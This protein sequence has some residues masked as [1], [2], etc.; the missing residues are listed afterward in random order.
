[1]KK[2]IQKTLLT[3]IIV[4]SIDRLLGLYLSTLYENN[5]YDHASGDVNKILKGKTSDTLI[6]G[7]SRVYTMIDPNIIGNNIQLVSKP[8]KHSYYN[9]A[10]VDLMAQYNKLPKKMLIFNIE[11]EDVYESVKPRLIEDVCYLKYYYYSNDFIRRIINQ[12]S[13]LE[14][15]KYLFSSYRFNGENF[16]LVTNPFQNI[17]YSNSNT[18]IPLD[19]TPN[20]SIRLRKG[21]EEMKSLQLTK[22]N[23]DFFTKMNHLIEICT[24]NRIKLVILY[25]PNYLLPQKFNDARKII[26]NYCKTNDIE[27]LDFSSEKCKEFKTR[28]LWFDHI[29]L[30]RNGATQYSL[31]LKKSLNNRLRKSD[32]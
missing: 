6:I 18:F 17:T 31:L 25:G 8:A 22:I 24:K 15:F 4:I 13:I 14:K 30:N 12:K 20:D 11:V 16:T 1:M 23:P 29:H 28:D 5:Y 9:I 3:I 27:F 2:I 32:N 21:I 19:K 10:V 7:S 26:S